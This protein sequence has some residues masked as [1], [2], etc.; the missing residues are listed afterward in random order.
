MRFLLFPGS[1]APLSYIYPPHKWEN[2]LLAFIT[3]IY[4]VFGGRHGFLLLSAYLK[5][6]TV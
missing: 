5:V 3:D 2:I 1:N 4:I 6:S